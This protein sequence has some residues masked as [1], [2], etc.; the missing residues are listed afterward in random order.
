M[1]VTPQEQ[2]GFIPGRSTTQAIQKVL[3]YIGEALRQ[4]RGC[5]YATF[6]DYQKAFDGVNRNIL[7]RKLRTLLGPESQPL[8]F[9]SSIL[10]SNEISISDGHLESMNIA[11][12]NGVLQGDPLSPML[13]NVLTN[14]IVTKITTEEV[15]ILL[16]ADDM[17]I[18]SKNRNGMQQAINKLED[19]TR[20]N[21]LKIN[22]TKTKVM[23]F[24]RGGRTNLKD[25]FTC[26]NQPLEMTKSYK[27]LGVTLQV[28]GFT[29]TKH[30][31]DKTI[32]A[33]KATME[34]KR[35]KSLSLET[36]TKLFRLKIAPVASHAIELIWP[37]L[38]YKN[39]KT[40]DRVKTRYLKKTLGVS[41][42]APNRLVYKLVGTSNFIDDLMSA[43]NLA[44]TQA[45]RKF[46]E[47]HRQKAAEIDPAFY[48]TPAMTEEEWKTANYELRHLYTRGAIHGFHHRVCN[49]K[50][51]HNADSECVCELCNR[52]C[53]QYHLFVCTQR[54]LPIS[55]YAKDD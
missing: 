5:A 32:A 30:I 13:F 10:E 20:E 26:G 46:M 38:N 3:E 6:V 21:E 33:I 41:K 29:F 39:V 12:T 17:V 4:P 18:L 48:H 27:Y 45:S 37:H 55:H 2:Y 54:T 40:L 49:R 47:E 42:Y 19:W 22:Q 43:H 9:I 23:K 52:P 25:T 44:P 28:T 14:D 24:R 35:L 31:E 15:K 34:I 1:E 36:A 8:K 50:G 16:Y 53:T 11:Q 51:F 7:L